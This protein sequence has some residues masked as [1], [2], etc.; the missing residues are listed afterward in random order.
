MQIFPKIPTY[1]CYLR[2]ALIVP[3]IALTYTHESWRAWVMFGIYVVAALTDWL[4]G[5]L[6]R[7][8]NVQT[9]FG[10]MIDQISDKL[11]IVAVVLTLTASGI[12]ANFALL[13]ALIIVLREIYVSGLREYLASQQIALPVSKLGKWKTTSQMLALGLLII[14]PAFNPRYMIYESGFA[15]L[16]VAALLSAISAVQYSSALREKSA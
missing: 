9:A 11:F 4:D 7:R 14:H 3:F 16:W 12:L 6:A 8:W 15:L 1:L 5:F 2:I 10:A 13:A